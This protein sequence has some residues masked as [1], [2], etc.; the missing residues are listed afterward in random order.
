ML[1]KRCFYPCNSIKV[2][3]LLYYETTA[4]VVF[5]RVMVTDE[6][7]IDTRKWHKYFECK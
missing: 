5:S 7:P 6:L 1:N 3:Q 2:C 4:W